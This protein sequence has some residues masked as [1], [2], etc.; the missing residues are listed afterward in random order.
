M[1]FND[2]RIIVGALMRA[3]SELIRARTRLLRD[4]AQTSQ[5]ISIDLTEILQALHETV[6]SIRADKSL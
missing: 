6:T 1:T 5:E 4:A 3:Q 2:R